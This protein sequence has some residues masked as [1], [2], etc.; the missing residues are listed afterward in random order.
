[1]GVSLDERRLGGKKTYR[2]KIRY[3]GK[4]H[5]IGSF[6]TPEEAHQ[7]YLEA[8]RKHHAGNTL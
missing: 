8:K 3:G 1:M 7:A 5:R 6:S 2:A 4:Q